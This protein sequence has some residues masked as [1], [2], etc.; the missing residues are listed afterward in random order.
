M[1]VFNFMRELLFMLC[2][3]GTLGLAHVIFNFE[4]VLYEI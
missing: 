4:T 2:L 1:Q 3:D